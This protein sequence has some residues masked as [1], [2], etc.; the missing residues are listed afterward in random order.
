MQNEGIARGSGEDLYEG[1]LF[2]AAY[3]NGVFSGTILRAGDQDCC[4]LPCV[5]RS[6]AYIG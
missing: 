2:S 1:G 4:D 3:L 5:P 6:V